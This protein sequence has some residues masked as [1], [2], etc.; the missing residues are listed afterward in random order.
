VVGT[1]FTDTVGNSPSLTD[2][3]NN[4]VILYTLPGIVL[5]Y[6]TGIN[7]WT[8]LTSSGSRISEPRRDNRQ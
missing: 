7:A 4:R 5:V 8:Q 3:Q 1:K 2:V 6:I